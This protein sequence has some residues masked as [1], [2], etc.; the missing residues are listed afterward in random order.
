MA[1]PGV[2]DSKEDLLWTLFIFLIFKGGRMIVGRS[3][4][5]GWRMI[6]K[7]LEDRGGSLPLGEGRHPNPAEPSSRRFRLLSVS[8]SASTC[9]GFDFDLF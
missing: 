6:E 3:L 2:R 9:L 4:E 5:E 8:I 7:W 1:A